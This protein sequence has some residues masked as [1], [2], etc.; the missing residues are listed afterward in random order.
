MGKIVNYV[1][2]DSDKQS[3]PS[4]LSPG[5]RVLKTCFCEGPQ[6]SYHLLGQC[7]Y[8]AGTCAWNLGLP[9]AKTNIK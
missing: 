5:K 6:E 9:T 1:H 4:I 8:E 2:E 3:R 7:V